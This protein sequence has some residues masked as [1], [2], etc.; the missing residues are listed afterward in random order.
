MSFSF[1]IPG[2][3]LLYI[4]NVFVAIS[5]LSGPTR[6]SV[7]VEAALRSEIEYWLFFDTCR[8][9]LPWKTEHFSVVKIYCDGSRRALGGTLL[10]DGRISESR[11]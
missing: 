9:C 2:W 6:P 5:H 3:K 11:E 4:S 1:A 10:K 7:K 8:D